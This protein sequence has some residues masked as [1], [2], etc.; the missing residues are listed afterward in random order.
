MVFEGKRESTEEQINHG[1]LLKSTFKSSKPTQTLKFL[2][3]RALRNFL[4]CQL[5]EWGARRKEKSNEVLLAK[6]S[7]LQQNGGSIVI[8]HLLPTTLQFLS[9]GQLFGRFL[10]IFV[11]ELFKPKGFN[12][13]SFTVRSLLAGYPL[14]LLN[15]RRFLRLSNKITGRQHFTHFFPKFQPVVSQRYKF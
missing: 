13:R 4:P 11:K 6:V 7:L 5:D 14:G 10:V 3:K 1:A 9:Q 15:W 12:L 8:K 2:V